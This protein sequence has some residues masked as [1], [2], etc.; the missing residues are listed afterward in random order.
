[1]ICLHA[2]AVVLVLVRVENVSWLQSDGLGI[3]LHS[4]ATAR[5]PPN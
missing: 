1:M 5:P 2:C 4:S 3:D